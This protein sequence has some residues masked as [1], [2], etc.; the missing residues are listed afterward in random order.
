MSVSN[1]NEPHAF[2]QGEQE[3]RRLERLWAGD[4]GDAYTERNAEA[5]RKRSEFWKE[6][7]SRYPVTSVLEVGCNVGAN[8]QW[9]DALLPSG[10][11]YG[12][13]INQRALQTLNASLSSVRTVVGTARCLPFQDGALDLV[14]T[15]GVLIHQP[16]EV[17]PIVMEEVVR[18]SRRY[19]LCAEYYADKPTGIAYRGQEGALFK[20]DFGRLYLERFPNLRLL[21]KGFL[22]RS[23]GGW[24]DVT[25]WVFEK[26]E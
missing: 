4:F 19:V 14:F 25:Y 26:A 10:A 20:R 1:V 2:R 6:F 23:E 11:L 12:L 16:P 24:D 15:V 22:P 3:V 13:D 18:C 17:L 21:Q 9:I 8:L 5:G 7:L